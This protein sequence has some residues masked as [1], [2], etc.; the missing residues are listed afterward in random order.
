[1]LRAVAVDRDLMDKC[2]I[3]FAELDGGEF[4]EL[5][6]AFR[7]GGSFT[8]NGTLASCGRTLASSR[9]VRF[10]GPRLRQ[11]VVRRHTRVHGLLQTVASL[12]Q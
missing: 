5:R 9:A 4:V 8:S 2:G 10:M 3:G 7:S 12:P 6:Q 11:C 1:M